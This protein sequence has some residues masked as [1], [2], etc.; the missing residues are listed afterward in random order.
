MQRR[1]NGRFLRVFPILPF[2]TEQERAH[3][4]VEKKKK[5]IPRRRSVGRSVGR[6]GRTNADKLSNGRKI[7]AIK[8]ENT[9]SDRHFL[10]TPANY[11]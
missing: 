6:V 11:A 2:R 5:K 4:N 8:A 7:A 1:R 3:R 9:S 10:T